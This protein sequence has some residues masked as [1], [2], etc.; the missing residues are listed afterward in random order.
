MTQFAN[1]A[2]CGTLVLGGRPG[3]MAARSGETPVRVEN[4]W[5]ALVDKDTFASVQARMAAKRPRALHPRTV[6]S[7]YLLSGLLYCS[8]GS[9]MIGRSAKS[10]RHYYY[11][12]NRQFKQGADGC[13]ARALPKDRLERLVINQIK[14]RVLNDEWLEELVRLVNVEL[15]ASHDAYRERLDTID[16][17]LTDAR[18]RLMKL[19]D[20]LETGKLSLDDLAPR[21]KR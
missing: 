11:T 3:H 5:P 1:E 7:F 13:G 20:A 10:H 17:E 21:I 2:Y 14:R 8:C 6:P 15:D 19:Y 12:C 16:V 9:A 18:A 4:A